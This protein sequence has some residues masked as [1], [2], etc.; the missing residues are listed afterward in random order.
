[1]PVEEGGNVGVQLEI[2]SPTYLRSSN[3]QSMSAE[4]VDVF[5]L[6][7]AGALTE[8]QINSLNQHLEAGG[9]VIWWIDSKAAADSFR[10]FEQLGKDNAVFSGEQRAW[11]ADEPHRFGGGRF[12][13]PILSVFEGP[14]RS[15]LLREAFRSTLHCRLA[16]GRRHCCAL[17]MALRFSASVDRQGKNSRIRRPYRSARQQLCEGADVCAIAS[18][19]V[20]SSDARPTRATQ[21][22]S[23]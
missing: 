16:P 1:M 12:E 8:A 13:D 6:V 21:P 17:M 10:R 14:A 9:G 20:A 19:V 2:R 22:L 11:R 4:G 7:E 18:S 15:A 3:N 5:V 23:R